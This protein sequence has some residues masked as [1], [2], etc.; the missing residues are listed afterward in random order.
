MR[1]IRKEYGGQPIAWGQV[2]FQPVTFGRCVIGQFFKLCGI[3]M[4]LQG[5]GC[6]A[7]GK[8]FQCSVYQP[9]PEAMFESRFDIAYFEQLIATGGFSPV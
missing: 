7:T 3:S 6:S 5:P 9:G 2:T 8:R 1:V 4:I